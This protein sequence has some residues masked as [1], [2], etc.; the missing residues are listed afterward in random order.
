MLRDDNAVHS[1][2]A[3]A[4]AEAAR[5]LWTLGLDAG[6]GVDPHT[7]EFA[8]GALQELEHLQEGTPG[9]LRQVLEGAQIGAEQL[10]VEPFH[11]LIEVI[12]NADDLGAT[13]IRV[14]ISNAGGRQKLLIVHDGSR[15]RLE[16]ALAMALTFISTKRADSASKGR[17][18]IGLK[19]LGRLGHR[20]TV[21]CPPYHFKIE[22]NKI[23]RAE[24]SDSIAGLYEHTANQTLLTLDLFQEF[25]LD[26]FQH[27]FDENGAQTLLF[28]DA[29]RQLK[30]TDLRQRKV[31][32]HH[33]LRVVTTEPDLRL[34]GLAEPCRCTVLKE[35][36]TGCQWTRY[37]IQQKVTQGLQRKH[38]AIGETMPISVALPSSLNGGGR[39]YAGLPIG[40]ITQLPF[41][42]NAQFDVDTSR[43]SVQ[44]DALNEWI[45]GRLADLA[46]AVALHLLHSNPAEGWQA[47]PLHH[48]SASSDRWLADR[49]AEL[50]STIK[51]KVRQR[52]HI[53][54]DGKPRRLRE[55]V[56]E[57]TSLRGLIG[58]REAAGLQPKLAFLPASCRDREDRW[59]SVLTELDD[60]TVIDIDEAVSLFD[61]EDEDLSHREVRWFVRLAQVAISQGLGQRVAALRSVISSDDRRLVPSV[62]HQDGVILLKAPLPNALATRLGLTHVVHPVYVSDWPY[63]RSVRKW[64]EEEGCLADFP[65]AETTLRAIAARDTDSPAIALEDLELMELR[66]ALELVPPD[67]AS[68]LGPSVGRVVAVQVQVW[69]GQK[70]DQE[71]ARIS[72]AYLPASIEDRAD[73]WSK[74]AS[75][76]PGIAWVHPRYEKLLQRKATEHARSTEK[77]RL[78]SRA[79]FRLLGAE[80]APRLVR[81]TSVEARYGDPAHPIVWSELAESQREALQNLSRHATHLKNDWFAPDLVAVLNDIARDRKMRDRS[82]RARALMSTLEREWARLYAASVNATAVYSSHSWQFAGTVPTTWIAHAMD[83]AWLTNEA[84]KPCAPRHVAVRTPATEAI[85]GDD[86]NLF[87]REL[88]SSDSAMPVLRALWVRTDPQVS[89]LIEQL[90]ELR[91]SGRV[92]PQQQLELRYAAIAAACTKRD[93]GPDERVGD[94]TVRQLRA[95]FG[96]QRNRPGLIFLNGR[97]LSP[98]QVFLGPPIFGAL[99]PFVAAKSAANALWRVLRIKP[100]SLTDCIE[101]LEEIAGSE[102]DLP[103]PQILVNTYAHMEDSLKEASA[104]E[105]EALTRLPI[106]TG[107]AWI[108]ERPIYVT[109]SP[110]MLEALSHYLP[111]WHSPVGPECVPNLINAMRVEALATA[112]FDPVVG[113]DAFAR[114]AHIEG[115]F[116]LA[117]KLLEDWLARHDRELARAN[118]VPWESIASARIA[119]DPDLKIDLNGSGLTSTAVPAPVYVQHD[120]LTFYFADMEAVAEDDGGDAVASLFER[121][122]RVKLALAWSQCWAKAGKGHRALVGIEE[123]QAQSASLAELFAQ[124]TTKRGR[125]RVSPAASKRG[126]DQT[127][128]PPITPQIARQLKTIEQFETKSVELSM[129]QGSKEPAVPG[130]RGLRASV[131]AGR[132][133]GKGSAPA[134][135]TAPVAYSPEEKESLALQVL[136]RAI[137]GETTDLKDYRHLRGVGADALDKLKR[138]FEIKAYYGPLPDDITMTANEA[139]RSLSEKDKFFLAIIAGLEQGYEGI[140]KIFPDP[141]RWLKI[142]EDTSIKLTGVAQCKAPIE[143]RFPNNLSADGAD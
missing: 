81:P 124:A 85:F 42:L 88:E 15:V 129:E 61:W 66:E 63:A 84:G 25:D 45:F 137:N 107:K 106:W 50:A 26:A 89:E 75:T 82:V 6:S 125:A 36:G 17:W 49:L 113:P 32:R 114:G 22:S 103:V 60:S 83:I 40:D 62:P 111:M 33:E 91:E 14:A 1:D 80:V 93:L 21:H 31:I 46:S 79:F 24:P 9:V 44:H 117:V 4:G 30:M 87:A 141:L 18:G 51:Q 35:A 73:G 71:I 116:R 19:T 96:A 101:V 138:Y 55:L 131:P 134:P 64:L 27:W 43:R 52:A 20:L 2:D 102:E 120:P 72:D 57:D 127:T 13:E 74:A 126:P 77:R 119:C 3:R 108:R 48:E 135:R 58:E 97:W 95:R 132:D 28:L 128:A 65:D 118:A 76:T 59:R 68:E 56:Y 5:R 37:D 67:A 100:P 16:H 70:K 94:L 41:S 11:G 140:V 86:R 8:D 53:S 109:T 34:P 47:I 12:Q 122:D 90:E 99:R 69:Q 123:E 38:K 143:I 105:K 23:S 142:K 10:N 110:G 39:L 92:V 115:R 104:R 54:V 29:V 112:S 98:S 133:I 136:Q 78:A 121:G 139:D 130:R 7:Q